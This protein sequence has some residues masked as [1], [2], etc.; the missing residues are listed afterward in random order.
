MHIL[1]L[2][3]LKTF[4]SAGF[5]SV[6]LDA[7]FFTALHEFVTRLYVSDAFAGF[8]DGRVELSD[9]VVCMPAQLSVRDLIFSTENHG[10]TSRMA[11][12]KMGK[13]EY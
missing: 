11:G 8:C 6:F 10:N 7:Y 2:H 12:S 1:R 5:A 9:F 4:F 3:G 13:K